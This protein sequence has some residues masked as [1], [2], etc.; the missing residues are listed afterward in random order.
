MEAGPAKASLN[1]ESVD[2]VVGQRAGLELEPG[3]GGLVGPLLINHSV[4]WMRL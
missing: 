1:L 4:F 3:L 2:L